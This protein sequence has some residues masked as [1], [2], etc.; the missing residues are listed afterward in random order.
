MTDFLYSLLRWR[1]NVNAVARGKV[2]Q[3]VGRVAAGKATGRLFSR[4]FR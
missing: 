3:R 2:P 4:L 1:N